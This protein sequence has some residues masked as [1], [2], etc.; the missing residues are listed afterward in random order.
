MST[1]FSMV[2][3]MAGV[4]LASCW[5]VLGVECCKR[6]CSLRCTADTVGSYRELK[7]R[8]RPRLGSQQLL[9]RDRVLWHDRARIMLS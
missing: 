5:R 6:L 1:W 7:R 9:S 4:V 2:D 8:C 3:G